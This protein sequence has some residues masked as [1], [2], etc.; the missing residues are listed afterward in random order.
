MGKFSLVISYQEII[1]IEVLK[2]YNMS[3]SLRISLP[4]KNIKNIHSGTCTSSSTCFSFIR[5]LNL[6]H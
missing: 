1:L 6:L 5:M 3:Y 2:F 4:Q